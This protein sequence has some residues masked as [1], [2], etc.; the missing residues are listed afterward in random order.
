MM[1]DLD[2]SSSRSRGREE[3]ASGSLLIRSVHGIGVPF[4]ET[5][6]EVVVR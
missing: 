3:I 2:D 1:D 5:N 6:D 4:G